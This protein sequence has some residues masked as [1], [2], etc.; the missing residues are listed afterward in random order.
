[1]GTVR[2][3][4]KRNGIHGNGWTERQDKWYRWEQLNKWT[5]RQGHI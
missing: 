4:D 2:Q 1:M 3:V 5:G